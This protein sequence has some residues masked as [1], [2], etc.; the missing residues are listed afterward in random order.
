M[1][2]SVYEGYIGGS[3]VRGM[4]VSRGCCGSYEV[5]D[6]FDG[7]FDF[8]MSH[9]AYDVTRLRSGQKYKLIDDVMVFDDEAAYYM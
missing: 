9:Y 2:R 6:R 8:V 4:R 3:L 1:R 7:L 5:A